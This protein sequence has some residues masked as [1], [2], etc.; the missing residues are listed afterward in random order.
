MCSA[1]AGYRQKIHKCSRNLDAEKETSRQ[2][3]LLKP[4]LE[5]RV[6]YKTLHLKA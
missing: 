3:D 2:T 4:T 6:K 5:E 1:E